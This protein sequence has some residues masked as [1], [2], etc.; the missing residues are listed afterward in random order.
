MAADKD[1]CDGS[2]KNFRKDDAVKWD[3]SQGKVEGEVLSKVTGTKKIKGH[4]AKA[5]PDEPQYEVESHK[6][7]ARAVHHPEELRRKKS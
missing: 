7:G 3:S 1:S 4:T 6:T 2:K 5:F